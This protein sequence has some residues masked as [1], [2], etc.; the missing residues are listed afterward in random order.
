MAASAHLRH[1][2]MSC[3]C[4]AAGGWVLQQ[5]PAWG[6]PVADPFTWQPASQQWRS[7]NDEE[8]EQQAAAASSSASWVEVQVSSHA[9]AFATGAAAAASSCGALPD[10][11]MAHGVHCR[12]DSQSAGITQACG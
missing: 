11:C 1:I 2:C 10:G 5:L 12:A 6:L 4:I 7:S 8:P 3:F 9:L